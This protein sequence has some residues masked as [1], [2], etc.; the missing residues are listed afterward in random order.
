MPKIKKLKYY[1]YPGNV[2]TK[3]IHKIRLETIF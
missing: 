1:F 3:Q 2:L